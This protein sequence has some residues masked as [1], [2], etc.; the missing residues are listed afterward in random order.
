[1]SFGKNI[2]QVKSDHTAGF[3]QQID[4]NKSSIINDSFALKP[5]SVVKIMSENEQVS[6]S[7]MQQKSA[8]KLRLNENCQSE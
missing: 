5:G 8:L 1:M 7:G 3:G 4:T 2:N 6:V